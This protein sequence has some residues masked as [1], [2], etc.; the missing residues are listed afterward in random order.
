MQPIVYNNLMKYLL[1]RGSSLQNAFLLGLLTL[2]SFTIIVY[3][4]DSYTVKCMC[5]S[6]F[7]FISCDLER[8]WAENNN[9]VLKYMTVEGKRQ[10]VLDVTACRQ[11]FF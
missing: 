5:D 3:F 4:S 7:F 2:F 8:K 11:T 1:F 6:F 9:N 10:D